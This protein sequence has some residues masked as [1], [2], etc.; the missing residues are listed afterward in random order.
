MLDVHDQLA[1]LSKSFQSN[2]LLIFDIAKNV[3]KT[4][5]SLK[6]LFDTP[7]ENEKHFW[8]EVRK[9]DSADVLRT[10]HLSDGEEGRTLFKVDRKQV[11]DGLESHLIERYLKM[12]DNDVL[13]SM[14]AFDHRHWPPA[15][16]LEGANDEQI[17]ELYTAFKGFFDES[18]TKEMVVE[19]WN[20][21]QSHDCLDPRPVMNAHVSRLMVARARSLPR[22]VPTASSPGG[23]RPHS[24]SRHVRV[25]AHLL[26]DERHQDIRAQL[27]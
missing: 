19:Q 22:A 8:I 10:C 13:N 6:K 4:L 14:S 18:E 7:G 23:H 21:M 26:A 24:P 2:S 27:G 5:R 16:S 17:E 1:I 25:R 3:N 11:I 15:G 20:D 12:L 9:D